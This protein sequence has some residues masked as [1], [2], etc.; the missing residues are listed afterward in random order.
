MR[1]RREGV[2]VE[3][4]PLPTCPVTACNQPGPQAGAHGSQTTNMLRTWRTESGGL[5]AMSVCPLKAARDI[6]DAANAELA[7]LASGLSNRR[8]GLPRTLHS[9]SDPSHPG[10]HRVLRRQCTHSPVAAARVQRVGR[11][12]QRVHAAADA[13]EPGGHAISRVTGAVANSVRAG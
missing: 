11:P 12:G 4:G 9:T 5:L 7:A 13:G 1:C 10:A 8:P 3:P 2:G 6:T